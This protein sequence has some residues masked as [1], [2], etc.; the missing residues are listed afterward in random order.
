MKLV[1]SFPAHAPRNIA[2]SVS[3]ATMIPPS[4]ATLSAGIHS[5]A[6]AAAG[7]IATIVTHPFDVV[8]VCELLIYHA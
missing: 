3:I 5:G 7:G 2:E 8:K 4:S 1:R 6:A